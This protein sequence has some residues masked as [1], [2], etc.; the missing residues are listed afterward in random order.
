[1]SYS[2]KDACL[3]FT[4][5]PGIGP[6][7]FRVIR[8][9]FGQARKALEVGKSEWESLGFS[10]NIIKKVFSF[11]KNFEIDK[12]KEKLAKLEI[13]YI[14][15]SEK[16]FPSKLTEIVDCPIGLFCKGRLERIDEMAIAVVGTRKATGYGREVTEKFVKGLASFG[17]TIVSGMARGIDGIAHRTALESGGRT[18]A[19]LGC[20]LDRVYPIE[21]KQLAGE[22]MKNGVLMSEYPPGT[23]IAP[24]NFPSRNRII[25]GLCL[26]VLVT[27]GAS[28]SGSKIT[29][30]QAVEQNREVFAVPGSITNPMSKAPAELIKMGAKLV[31]DEQDIIE[32]LGIKTNGKKIFE[33]NNFV[34]PEFENKE[35]EEIWNAIAEGVKQIDEIAR[36]SGI[37]ISQVTTAL[38]MMEIG[39]LVKHLGNGEY[40]LM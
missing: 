2:E 11:A 40:M 30:L 31:T 7:S 27:E 24:G 8:E 6:K 34:K 21:H 3:F 22:I 19:V 17:F 16:N 15:S 37:P 9:V 36:I 12:E 28:K 26:G 10:K 35:H 38:T 4:Y 29:A 20:G 14:G 13:S 18:I 25:S 23:E 5:C 33:A 1:M 39:G 32:E